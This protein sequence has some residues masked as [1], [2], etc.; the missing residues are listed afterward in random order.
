M[1]QNQKRG[2]LRKLDSME[3]QQEERER[4]EQSIIADLK[5]KNERKII[6]ALKLVPHEGSPKMIVPMFEILLG[7]ASD[8]VKMLLEKTVFNL[9]DPACV[10]P[11]I[12]LLEHKKYCDIQTAVLTS[13]WQSGL[14]VSNH[15]EIL[16]DT[17]INGDYMTVI[18]V[19][20]IIEHIE[21][22]DDTALTQAIQKMDKAVEVKSETQ[23]V[24]S[25]LR[26]LLLDKLLGEQ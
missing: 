6:G 26:Q 18:E 25:S 14:D 5:S 1:T 20:T 15:I 11:L 16:V 3:E 13:I 24:L 7:H 2:A 17:A 19:I 4:I 9:K 8:D 10:D 12:S 21:V 22:D 23:T